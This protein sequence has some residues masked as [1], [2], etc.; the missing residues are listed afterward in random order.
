MTVL[1]I[2]RSA[3][4]ERRDLLLF[5]EKNTVATVKLNFFSTASGSSTV[6]RPF[7]LATI[8]IGLL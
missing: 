7:K 2:N 8:E 3:I 6:K 4:Q 1:K 5:I